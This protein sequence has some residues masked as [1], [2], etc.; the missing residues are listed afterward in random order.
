[1]KRIG[2]LGLVVAIALLMGTVVPAIAQPHGAGPHADGHA[3]LV[4]K[5]TIEEPRKGPPAEPPARQIRPLQRTGILGDSLA[6]EAQLWAVVVGISDYAGTGSD[7]RYADDDAAEV[8][9]ALVE[10]YGYPADHIIMLLGDKDRR[11]Y[12]FPSRLATRSN[13]LAAIEEISDHESANDE[14][15]FYFSGHGGYSDADMDGDG[16]MEDE[17]IYVQDGQF[18]WDGELKDAFS[19]F[20]TSRIVFGFDSCMSGGMTDLAA[21]GRIVAMASTET[22]Y[23]YELGGRFRNGEF[24]YW[25]IEDGMYSGHADYVDSLGG[26]ADVTVEEAWDWANANCVYDTPTI[27]DLFA[28][29]L[30]LGYYG[31]VPPPPP[32][33]TGNMH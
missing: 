12:D 32:P 11:R 1:M 2:V 15:V 20:E 5:I 9:A 21:T 24:T 6:A 4:L 29:D 30:L 13:I 18:I 26:R 31:E 10:R 16:E 19:G 3:H 33:P 7:L 14:A 23:S 22:G 25:F 27:D 17:G 8:R 28:D